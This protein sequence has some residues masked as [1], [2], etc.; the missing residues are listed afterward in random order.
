[1]TTTKNIPKKTSLEQIFYILIL[2]KHERLH[3]IFPTRFWLHKWTEDKQEGSLA[4]Q[5]ER[6]TI[7]YSVSACLSAAE[8]NSSVTLVNNQ[9]VPVC[10][11]WIFFFFS[12]DPWK[13]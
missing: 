1:M 4:E 10:S 7:L 8:F 5:L 11:I 9:L 6:W 3:V 2:S 12:I 13:A